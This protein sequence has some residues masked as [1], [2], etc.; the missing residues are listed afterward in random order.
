M[1]PRVRRDTGKTGSLGPGDL[2]GRVWVQRMWPWPA[3]G[4]Q[5][6][7]SKRGS[8]EAGRRKPLLG[9]SPVPVCFRSW[10]LNTPRRGTHPAQ[11]E[12]CRRSAGRS[13]P[14]SF[15]SP[16][17]SLRAFRRG[18]RGQVRPCARLR[19]RN[20]SKNDESHLQATPPAILGALLPSAG[21]AQIHLSTSEADD[22]RDG[23]TRQGG[24]GSPIAVGMRATHLGPSGNKKGPSPDRRWPFH[25]QLSVS[26]LPQVLTLGRHPHPED[27][28]GHRT[29]WEQHPSESR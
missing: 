23:A 17:P 20:V 28:G 27:E 5:P 21:P 11:A 14:V 6:V 22:G 1:N 29:S 10:G 9:T 12:P 26:L 3:L 25:L 2:G 13:Q 18:P 7:G 4:Q 8:R 15:S 16:E 24:C 19:Q